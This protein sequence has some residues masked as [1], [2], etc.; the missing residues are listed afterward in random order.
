MDLRYASSECIVSC[1]VSTKM[2]FHP[3]SDF[4]FMIGKLDWKKL[5]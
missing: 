4:N 3:I 5:V 2:D 1:A